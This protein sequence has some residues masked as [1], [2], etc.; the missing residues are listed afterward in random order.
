MLSLYFL[1]FI[2]R[3]YSENS[4]LYIYPDRHIS[5]QNFAENFCTEIHDTFYQCN[6]SLGQLLYYEHYISPY[7]TTE[8]LKADSYTYSKCCLSK[9]LQI[10]LLLCGDVH[11][12][13]G[14]FSSKDYSF[15]KQ[16][17]LH[18]LHL[19]VRSLLPDIDE[20][21]LLFRETN[22]V[23]VGITETWLD[24]TVFDSEIAID[25]YSICRKDRNRHGGGVCLYIRSDIA[26]NINSDLYHQEL[27]AVFIE[28]LLPKSKP[29]LFSVLYR[30][31][32]QNDFYDILESV[33]VNYEHFSERESIF[34]GD[35]N[36]NVA[37]QS[38]C[39]LNST[40]KYFCDLFSL[41]QLISEHTRIYS[42]TIIDLI[43]V[44]DCHKIS[45][46]G[47]I[48][49]NISDHQL[50]FCTRKITHNFIGKHN[51]VKL[52]SLKNYNKEAFQQHLVGIDW[53]NVLNCDNVFDAWK[54]FKSVFILALDIFAPV[55]DIRIKQRSEKWIDSN[56]LQCIK[57]R[58]KAF[59]LYKRNKNDENLNNFRTLRNKAQSLI[60]NAKKNYFN[61]TLES[62]KSDSKT[63]WKC[64]KDLGLPSKGTK[65]SSNICL[66]IDNELCFDKLKIAEKFNYFYTTV[67][68]KLVENLPSCI[69]SFGTSFVYNFYSSK[70]VKLDNYS[71]SIVSEEKCFKYINSLS[72]NKAVGLDGIPSRFIRDAAPVIAHPFSHII[73]LSI[74]QGAVPEDLK[75][76]RVVPLFKKMIKQKLATTALFLFYVFY[77]KF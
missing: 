19:N 8:S 72:V 6:I 17:G 45:Q 73:N 4:E 40:L 62:N 60:H 76:A 30:P 27:E 64:L 31:P 67:A 18:F 7:Y 53:L 2:L 23:C 71:F 56:I 52:R 55:K 29:I 61:E 74:I 50:I 48:D 42:S 65:A 32:S 15:S 44:S 47:V 51:T 11:P 49:C 35:F 12:C 54:N 16:R 1:A 33:L 70:G 24:D 9:W 46:S 25:N 13:P 34:L 58:D 37:C 63:L 68:S 3:R 28:L 26:F 43:L 41:K 5:G 10:C 36:T 39:S 57:E 75:S 59:Q 22:A 66:K 69:S 21:R 20:V 38:K 14:P 77:L